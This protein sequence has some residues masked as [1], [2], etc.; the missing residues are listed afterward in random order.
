MEYSLVFRQS[1]V[2]GFSSALLEPNAGHQALEIAGAKY[3]RRL[4]PVACMPSL[5]ARPH[6]R[7][8]N[9]RNQLGDEVAEGDGYRGPPAE[10]YKKPERCCDEA[11]KTC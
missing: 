9:R 11:E 10:R 7:N 4:F 8:D 5:G 2:C 3:E 1:I 6:G